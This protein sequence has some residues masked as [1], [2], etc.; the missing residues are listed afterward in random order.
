MSAR[1][2]DLWDPIGP[3]AT[4]AADGVSAWVT[5]RAVARG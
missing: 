1:T 2:I 5:L 4:R 3:Y